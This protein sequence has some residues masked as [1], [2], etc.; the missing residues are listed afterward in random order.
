[1]KPPIPAPPSGYQ[2]DGP[3]PPPP[4]YAL[5]QQVPPPPQG[6]QLDKPPAPKIDTPKPAAPAQ[7]PYTIRGE[8][9]KATGRVK[10]DVQGLGQ[11]YG[12]VLSGKEPNKDPEAAA[13][14]ERFWGD[15]GDVA[16]APAKGVLRKYVNPA[17]GKATGASQKGIEK[18][19]KDVGFMAQFVPGL[20]ALEKTAPAL[21]AGGAA[22]KAAAA[23]VKAV[24]RGVQET[25]APAT[26]SDRA[27]EV[28]H[29]I[30]GSGARSQLDV[31]RASHDLL[32]FDQ[33]VQRG[34]PEQ[35]HA[36]VSFIEG[37]S[38]PAPEGVKGMFVGRPGQKSFVLSPE[39]VAAM[40]KLGLTTDDIKVANKIRD[41]Y[42]SYRDKAEYLIRR[43]SG[44]A[45]RFVKD[46]Y[47]H[48]WAESPEVVEQRMSGFAK[49]GSG[50]NFKARSIPTMA[51]GIEA[52]LTPKYT[53]PVEATIV[54]S[55]N[56][57]NFLTTH[58]VQGWMKT[59]GHAKWY[60]PGAQPAG[61]VPLD[62]ILTERVPRGV[63]GREGSVAEN[64]EAPLDRL[65]GP[66]QR[67]LPPGGGEPGKL[68][69]GDLRTIEEK[70]LPAP[71]PGTSVAWPG[72]PV[73]RPGIGDAGTPKL[74]D[75]TPGM[76]NVTPEKPP[77]PGTPP[78]G[79]RDRAP[80]KEVL[81]APEDAARIYNRWI[82]KGFQGEGYE[83]LRKMSNGMTAIKLGMSA[84]HAMTMAQEAAVSSV[85][86]G[87]QA[88]SRGDIKTLAK[89]VAKAPTSLVTSGLRGK[90]MG[91]E[92]LGMKGASPISEKVNRA[93]INSGGRIRMDKLYRT[94]DGRTFYDAIK[95][96]TFGKELRAA[97]QRMYGA[98][99]TLAQKAQAHVDTAGNIVQSIF[100][101]PLF[102]DI[103]PA[104][105][106]GAFAERM[107]DFIK[108][109]PAATDRE[110]DQFA[111]KLQ[112]SVDNRFGEL[113]QDNLF[114]HKQMKQVSQILL[115][116]A[117][118]GI[119]TVR[120]IGGGSA[121]IFGPSV[122]GVLKGK[123]VTDRTAYVAA[124]VA[125]VAAENAMITAMKTGKPPTSVKDLEAYRTG[126]KDL[127]LGGAPERGM[128]P[129]Y[130]KDVFAAG[131]AMAPGSDGPLG[132][133]RSK[134][135]PGAQLLLDEATNENYAHQKV[136]GPGAAPGSQ[137]S[138]L[139][140]AFMPISV[141]SFAKGKQKGSNISDVER[142]LAVRPAPVYLTNPEALARVRA[143]KAR[144]DKRSAVKSQ[145]RQAARTE[146]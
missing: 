146:P 8:I 14:G 118:W 110:I 104:V 12:R 52:G 82:S 89:G 123:G 23:P 46:Y 112:D 37:R 136:Y 6:M 53:N 18:T 129:G 138:E 17:I 128:I 92:L 28:S 140:D 145:A 55:Q 15:V 122:K 113:V 49:Q 75:H 1:M 34:T 38:A 65:G 120:E 94:S 62:G 5:D 48:M 93:F 26:V 98:D 71:E 4:G 3:P 73:G 130:Q 101:G 109:N 31:E 29:F 88:A 96:K 126:G 36:L 63:S 81:Y 100:Q 21:E 95:S 108:A 64:P 50:R 74:E 86:R 79:A 107:E 119:G 84:F 127:R 142:A 102:E 72:K 135:S 9:D 20:S 11:M 7:K 143:S 16:T 91:E 116:S 90:R 22:A 33:K 131:D 30:R 25:F 39:D 132:M 76:R 139:V 40:K 19:E 77:E 70:A 54:Y 141:G 114:W 121:D 56:M 51:D 99:K 105:K 144:R 111:V 125:V 137:A 87:I 133:L 58:D 106:R 85:A 13:I 24:G 61:W 10:E 45:P 41:T 44:A 47:A 59:Q 115:T 134:L 57:S 42:K 83:A 60:R 43:N 2:L 97:A 67:A 35:T 117:T 68:P 69:P 103:I 78:E 124:L 80:Q 32:K 66:G 27:A